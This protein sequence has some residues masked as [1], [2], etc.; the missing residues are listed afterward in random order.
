MLRKL[1]CKLL[2]VVLMCC[3]ILAST[4]LLVCAAPDGEKH[5][6]FERVVNFIDEI[7]EESSVVETVPAKVVLAAFEMTEDSDAET[8]ACT[9]EETVWTEIQL[10]VTEPVEE[11]VPI[12]ETVP[13]S[14]VVV[15]T[16]E[17]VVEEM[18]YVEKYP[19]VP[20]F[21]Q[22]D[23][24]N[25]RYGG[26]GTVASHGCG[27]ASLSMVFSY[28][29]DEEIL[30]DRLAEEYGRYNTKCGSSWM[31]FPDSAEDYGITIENQT[32]KWEDVV[33]ALENGQVVIANAGPDSVFTDGGH[34]I[35]FYGITEDGKILVRDPNRYNYGEW[36]SPILKEGFANGFDQKYCRYNCFPCWIY[37]AKD[38]EALAEKH[39]GEA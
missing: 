18:V 39:A 7:T 1:I 32:W 35:V 23:Y 33:T 26:Y 10:A 4:T 34:F 24:P 6:D 31:L 21:F 5:D 15:I 13:E 16:E 38:V 12:L 36:S 29:M 11:T 25:T 37:E 22:T 9:I 14:E 2:M 17:P 3:A 30:P 19:E 27:I 8:L 28:L 20:H